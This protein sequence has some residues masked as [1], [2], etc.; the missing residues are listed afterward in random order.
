MVGDSD[1][2][3]SAVGADDGSDEV[4][5]SIG[6]RGYVL[7]GGDNFGLSK[8]A[9]EMRAPVAQGDPYGDERSPPLGVSRDRALQPIKGRERL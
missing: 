3:W 5:A 6:Y 7:D 2:A 1:Y 8:K 4:D 9:L